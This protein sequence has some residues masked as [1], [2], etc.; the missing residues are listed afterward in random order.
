M[1][2]SNLYVLSL[3]LSCL[4]ILVQLLT[5]SPTNAQVSLSSEAPTITGAQQDAANSIDVQRDEILAKAEDEWSQGNLR[6]QSGTLPEAEEC[7]RKALDLY[8]QVYP[9]A[10]LPE[11]HWTISRAERSL[12]H[13]L[14]IQGKT[15]EAREHLE[16][17]YQQ[18]LVFHKQWPTGNA[19]G[20]LALTCWDLGHVCQTEHRLREAEALYQ[21]ALQSALLAS[22]FQ[23]HGLPID[24]DATCHTS[25]GLIRSEVGDFRAAAENLQQALTL[26]RNLFPKDQY[27]N[28]HGFI[29]LNL[30][31]LARCLQQIG[32]GE[33]ANRCLVEAYDMREMLLETQAEPQRGLNQLI[34]LGYA[35]V[36]SYEQLS[37]WELAYLSAKRNT[38]TAERLPQEAGSLE[39]P[40][41]LLSLGTCCI[42]M[43]Y[44]EEAIECAERALEMQQALHPPAQY[45]QGHQTIA[46]AANLLG[47]CLRNKQ[48]WPEAAGRFEESHHMLVA[49]ANEEDSAKSNYLLGGVL[50]NWGDAL[51]HLDT[52]DEARQRCKE[53]VELLEKA[54]PNEQFPNG[55]DLLAVAT[56]NLGSV[57]SELEEHEEALRLLQESLAMQ[58]RLFPIDKYP[59]GH[60]R[61]GETHLRLARAL[62]AA[63]KVRPA[64]DAYRNS[65]DAYRKVYSQSAFPHGHPAMQ[66][67]FE[68]LAVLAEDLGES[69]TVTEC[70]HGL[71]ELS[72]YAEAKPSDRQGELRREAQLLHD[73]GW[74]YYQNQ[75]YDTAEVFFR[76]AMHIRQQ[77]Y[78]E[79]E[80]PEGLSELSSSHSWLGC[81][82]RELGR[83][84]EA[85]QYL[86]KETELREA[87]RASGHMLACDHCL[88]NSYS[89]HAEVCRRLSEYD[90]AEK[91]YLRAIELYRQ[92]YIQS[93]FPEGQESI[94]DCLNGLGVVFD[95]QDKSEQARD[96]YQQAVDLR[97]KIVQAGDYPSVRDNLGVSLSNLGFVLE[98]LGKQEEADACFAEASTNPAG[99]REV[100]HRRIRRERKAGEDILGAGLSRSSAERAV[101]HFVRALEIAEETYP[102]SEFPAGHLDI[103]ESRVY[104]GM[105]EFFIGQTEEARI[106]FEAALHMLEGLGANNATDAFQM[107][108]TCAGLLSGVYKLRGENAKAAQYNAQEQQLQQKLAAIKVASQQ[109]MNVAVADAGVTSPSGQMREQVLQAKLSRTRDQYPIGKYPNGSQTLA[110]AIEELADYLADNNQVEKAETLLLEALAMRRRILKE[111]TSELT[112]W[113][114]GNCLELLSKLRQTQNRFAEASDIYEDIYQ[115]SADEKHAGLV[116]VYPGVG[117]AEVLK[118]E[119][120]EINVERATKLAR[121]LSEDLDDNAQRRFWKSLILNKLGESLLAIGKYVE[122][123]AIFMKAI[124]GQEEALL[125][126]SSIGSEAEALN[127]AYF[128]QVSL[129]NLITCMQG[130]DKTDSQAYQHI[131]LRRGLLQASI[132]SRLHRTHWAENPDLEQLYE[133]YLQTRQELA[134]RFAAL[135]AK[136]VERPADTQKV[137]RDL[138]ERK[139]SLERRLATEFPEFAADS[140]AAEVSPDQ[141][142]SHLPDQS[143]FIDFLRYNNATPYTKSDG[144]V[145]LKK[146]PHYLATLLQRDQSVLCIDLGEAAPIETL[147]ADW[148]RAVARNDEV[149]AQRASRNLSPLLWQP[150]AKRLTGDITTI[151]LC[152]DGALAALAWG[153]LPAPDQQRILLEDY[154][155]AVVPSGRWLLESLASTSQPSAQTG[156]FLAVGNVDYD[157]K[158]LPPVNTLVSGDRG[159]LP[160]DA[161]QARWSALPGTL[162]EIQSL[163]EDI[164]D[165]NSAEDALR[166]HTLTAADATVDRV[167]SALCGARWAHLST[168]GFFAAPTYR[169]AFQLANASQDFQ[170]SYFSG[171]R[172]DVVGRNPLVLSGLVLAGANTSGKAADTS[173]GDQDYGI[174]S[175]EEIAALPLQ[176]LE[177]VVLSACETALGDVAGGEGVFGLQRAFH[178]GGAKNVVGSLWRVSDT[179]TAFLMKEFYK[180]RLQKEGTSTLEA[181]REAQLIV[182][183]HPE[184]VREYARDRGVRRIEETTGMNT[185]DTSHSPTSWWAAFVLSGSGE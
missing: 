93:K 60:Q 131:W 14:R 48:N 41:T 85:K 53:A 148:R 116:W 78:P 127:F 16:N 102:S 183:R 39:T 168:H 185:N 51:S 166:L 13:V 61:F 157:A 91:D 65:L 111:E 66:P 29:V 141:L 18:E 167:V 79:K 20:R 107:Q 178:M 12:G 134:R 3:P 96:Y 159:P 100:A 89:L 172:A 25:L 119:P 105:C 106:E 101:P 152:P 118:H 73:K 182:Y 144:S 76:R 43:G 37:E 80:Y 133:E 143:A 163:Q 145:D 47:I 112:K 128:S 17:A 142:A 97:R 10:E 6:L 117:W 71:A 154:A 120:S 58:Q 165:D 62:A 155:F 151:Y 69:E 84:H 56:R 26:R 9:P 138:T 8:Q 68:E 139:E 24:F 2:R 180:N 173:S 146:T 46:R 44:Y 174:L 122:A 92:F 54:Y 19:A 95:N 77:S 11:G 150:L 153:A 45:P 50:T 4:C 90:E 175:A 169:S 179:A 114:L 33:Q 113:Q 123:H 40:N 36:S 7:F 74:R 75:R 126:Y 177:L 23:E 171:E 38:E 181:L 27:P 94:A 164:P 109:G 87:L 147:I 103:A 110:S 149:M 108:A 83:L 124:S 49:L 156:T 137:L 15:E 52:L 31:D 88:A 130:I 161:S 63:G 5:C 136:D 64:F 32:D 55:S 21:Q 104:V 160:R 59:N 81:S 170:A 121:E 162:E 35:L 99:S 125:Q 28:G 22:P 70:E 176:D 30:Q 72:K 42:N 98:D 184:R 57:L 135:A 132:S 34:V 158:I 82:L 1:W 86:G 115:L 140:V 129:G 67:V